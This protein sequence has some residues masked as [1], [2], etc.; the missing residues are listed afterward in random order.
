MLENTLYFALLTVAIKVVVALLAAVA[1]KR[2]FV[3]RDV[4]RVLYYM[5]YICRS[6]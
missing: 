4:F 1:L 2:G 3:G 6:R 5:P